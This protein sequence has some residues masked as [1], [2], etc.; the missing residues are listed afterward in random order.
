[1]EK[2]A[3]P[4]L[5]KTA[6]NSDVFQ[7]DFGW[8]GK[9]VDYKA[10]QFFMME[11]VDEAGKVNRSYSVS[12][13]PGNAEGFSLCVKL[14]PDG[15]G[16]KVLRELALG[17]TANFMAPF[18]HFVLADSPKDM[19]MIA[20]GT[21]LAPFMAML[22]TVFERGFAGKVT[23]IFGVRHEEDLF[24]V[25]QLREW[26]KAHANFKAVVTLSQPG[27]SWTGDKGRVT[28]HLDDFDWQNVQV[29]I[30]G[31]GD[32]VKTVKMLMDEKGVPK[33]DIHLEQFTTL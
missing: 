19:L 4:L 18:G 9:S 5:R 32:M 6:L 12:S 13:V 7:F 15:R 16:S 25:E 11:V 14:L 27:D 20:T 1:M 31:N 29:Y 23:L 30:C 24:Y 22:P 21:G 2:F 8:A 3:A 26:E 10:G 28:D 33:T 17:A